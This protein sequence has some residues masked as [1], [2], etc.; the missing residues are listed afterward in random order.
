[1]LDDAEVED[2]QNAARPSDATG[3]K[4]GIFTQLVQLYE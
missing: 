2:D 1:M 3:A 4:V